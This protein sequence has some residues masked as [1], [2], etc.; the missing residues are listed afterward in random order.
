MSEEA[1][2]AARVADSQQARLLLDVS[3]RPLIS[4]LMGRSRS[5]SEVARELGLSVQR[6]HY[7]LGKLMTAGIAE[8]DSIQPRAGRAVRRY[9][10]GP[11]W[12][13][14]FEATGAETLHAFLAAQIMPRMELFVK[15][16]LRQIGD[17]Y[18]HWGFW[19]EHSEGSG[20][21][22][23]GDPTGRARELFEGDEPFLFNL[24]SMHLSSRNATALKRRLLAVLEEFE[25]LEDA[26]GTAYALGLLFAEGRME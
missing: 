24:G 14:P 15:L 1:L 17:V 9:R 22:N 13:V 11:R 8:L 20:S 19:L 21:L 25:T 16:S 26:G 7:L 2:P 6:A 5:A 3:L 12:F 10:V 18:S 23:L 4:V